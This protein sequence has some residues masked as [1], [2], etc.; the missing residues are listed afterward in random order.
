MCY[1]IITALFNGC[2]CPTDE[3]TH[4]TFHHI[5][6]FVKTRSKRNNLNSIIY[7]LACHDNMGSIRMVIHIFQMC[8][9]GRRKKVTD[10]NIYRNV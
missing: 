2:A 6:P 3:I 9:N 5:Q 1:V 4:W 8:S 10:C 7:N